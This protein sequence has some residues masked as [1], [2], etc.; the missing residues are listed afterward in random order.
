MSSVN[1]VII[2]SSSLTSTA[3]SVATVPSTALVLMIIVPIAINAPVQ[4]VSLL[5]AVVH[6]EEEVGAR[7]KGDRNLV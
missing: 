4:D 5:W 7:G 6:Q 1:I 3:V 2:L